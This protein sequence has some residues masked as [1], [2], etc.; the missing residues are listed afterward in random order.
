MIFQTDFV[1]TDRETKQKWV[2]EKYKPILKGKILDV[3]A[4]E[5]YIQKYLPHDVIIQV[6]TWGNPDIVQIDLENEVLPFNNNEFDCVMCLDVLEHLENIHACFDELCRVSVEWI[7]ISLPNPY[8]DLLN[9]FRSGKYMNRE[10]NMKFYGLSKEERPTGI[11][12]F[13]LMKL[14]SLY[15][16]VLKEWI[17]NMIFTGEDLSIAKVLNKGLF[18]F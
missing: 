15:L 11:N 12:G 2:S 16:T 6:L 9:Y 7:I 14:G 18:W 3:G 4:D 8:N 10:K 5:G 13:Q 17:F 1:Y